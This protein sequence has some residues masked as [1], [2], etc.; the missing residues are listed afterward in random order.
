[1]LGKA[2]A[3]YRIWMAKLFPVE[4]LGI[5]SGD[6]EGGVVDPEIVAGVVDDAVI[7]KIWLGGFDNEGNWKQGIL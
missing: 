6:K 5:Q 7:A 2:D 3:M 1:M 4:A